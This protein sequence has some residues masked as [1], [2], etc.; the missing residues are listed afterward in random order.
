MQTMAE[1]QATELGGTLRRSRMA[2]ELPVKH[3]IELM[4]AL[5]V[6]RRVH[7]AS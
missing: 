1:H 4:P 5:L 7:Y 2:P 6:P 3:R